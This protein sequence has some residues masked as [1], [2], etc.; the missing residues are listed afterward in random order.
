MSCPVYCEKCKSEISDCEYC[1]GQYCKKC[2]VEHTP[3]CKEEYDAQDADADVDDEADEVPDGMYFSKDKSICILD[4][5]SNALN[6]FV[7]E[8]PIL[9]KDYALNKELTSDKEMV[10]V[11]K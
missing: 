3:D 8:L 2:L 4:I 10:W 7:N 1:D 6:C 11:R 5:D 9:L